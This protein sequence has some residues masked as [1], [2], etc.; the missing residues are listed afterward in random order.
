MCAQKP[1]VVIICFDFRVFRVINKTTKRLRPR[2]RSLKIC[3]LQQPYVL[4]V[5]KYDESKT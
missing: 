2:T 4:Y 5:A 3:K 1:I